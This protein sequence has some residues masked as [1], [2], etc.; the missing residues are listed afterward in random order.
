MLVISKSKYMRQYGFELHAYVMNLD[1]SAK[2]NK[3]Y[4]FAT[5]LT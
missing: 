2:Y 1:T 5:T 3:S 4:D